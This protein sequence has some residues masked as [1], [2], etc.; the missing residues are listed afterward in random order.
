MPQERKGDDASIIGVGLTPFSR[1]S[2]LSALELQADAAYQALDDAGLGAPEVDTVITGYATTVNHIMPGNVLAEYLGAKPERAFGMNVGGATGLAMLAE[3]AR[4][5]RSGDARTVLVVGGENR[6][7]GQTRDAAIATLAQVG[8]ASHEV[9]LGANIPA[10]Y[11]LLA[12]EYLHRH[13]LERSEL[14]A[15]AVQM[16]T[17]AAEHPGAQFR[18]PITVD[19]VLAA[20]PIAEPLGLLDCCPMSDGAAAVVISRGD[21]GVRAVTIAGLGQAND[22]QHVSEADFSAFGAGASAGSALAEA[23]VGVEGLDIL[24][25][26]DSFTITLALLLEEIGIV[27]PGTAGTRAA[28]GLF[29]ADGRFPLNLHG[30]LLSYGHSGVAGGMAHLVEMVTQMRGEAAN[31]QLSTRPRRGLLHADG[32]VLSAHVSVVLDREPTGAGA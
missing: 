15:L 14:A 8:H 27:D 28:E 22:H 5:V 21:G 7:S 30:G 1:D 16:R 24:G 11:A 17:H 31:R 18:T 4:L 23:G 19:D 10:Y 2:G 12:S 6:A 20:P 25:I 3:A 29:A 32:G 26:Y 9:A 13:G